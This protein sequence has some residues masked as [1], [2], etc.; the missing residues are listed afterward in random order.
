MGI[1]IER[2]YLVLKMDQNTLPEGE[3]IEQG[4]LADGDNTVRIRLRH[5]K[6]TLTIK[7]A[8]EDASIGKGA[9]TCQEF[10]YSIPSQDVKKLLNATPYRVKKTRYVLESGIEL[11][12]FHDRH[13]GLIMAE[14]ESSDGAQ[15]TCPPGMDWIEVSSDK[16][17]SN[18]WLAKNGIPQK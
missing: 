12:I 4:Y 5:V 17:Y 1:E 8:P 13:E 6:G 3:E 9:V 18:A 2:K 10:E 11:D 15:A 14:Y 7:I 16:R